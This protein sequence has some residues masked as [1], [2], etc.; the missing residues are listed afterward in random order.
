MESDVLLMRMQPLLLLGGLQ[1]SAADADWE[2]WQRPISRAD[3]AAR[4]FLN[5]ELTIRVLPLRGMHR[6]YR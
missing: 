2:V 5:T 1:S 6:V 4:A 3:D